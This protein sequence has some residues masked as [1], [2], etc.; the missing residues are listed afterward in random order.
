MAATDLDWTLMEF[1]GV[2]HSFTNPTAAGYGIEALE[3]DERAD[4][5]SWQMLL[6]TLQDAFD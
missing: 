4:E 2:K 3:Y 5:Q 6:W 1:G